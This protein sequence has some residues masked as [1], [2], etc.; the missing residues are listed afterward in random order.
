M[1]R[2]KNETNKKIKLPCMQSVSVGRAY[3]LLRADVREHL[4]TAHDELGF[5]YCRFH[6]I[7]HDDMDIAYKKENGQIGYHWHHID[8]VFDYLLSIGMK[9][10]I[11]LNPMPSVIASGTQT[12]FWYEMNVTPP[13]E[14][15]MWYDLIHSFTNH[16]TDRYGMNEVEKWFFEVWNE[17]NLDCFWSGTQEEYFTMY[18]TSAEAVKSVNSKYKIGGPASAVAE[19][20]VDLIDY[21]SKENVPL[22]FVSTHLYPM[23]EYCRYNDRE[24]SPYELGEYYIETVKKT[25]RM[26]EQSSMPNLDIYWTEWN[27]LSTDST[28]NITF[29]GNTALDRLYGASCTVRNMLAVRDY[30]KAVS[31]WVVSDIF[32]EAKMS[33]TPFSGTYGLMNI[34]GV[35]KATYNAFLMLKKMCGY[36]IEIES[37]IVYP[38]GCGMAAAKE[39]GVYRILIWNNQL[40][41]IKEQ[42]I[43][44]DFIKIDGINLS[45]CIAEQAKIQKGRGSAYESWL[46][47]GKPANPT[48]FEEEFLK[49]CSKPEYTVLNMGDSIKFS[50]K[51]DEVCY[52]ELR[53]KP[54]DRYLA[55]KDL[56]LDEQLTTY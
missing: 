47:M 37:D 34:K 3:D 27:T 53:K 12:M 42:P 14:W 11:E 50:L 7:F 29:Q 38:T 45:E 56:K 18:K 17:P 32:E 20:V 49:A 10:F 39:N 26:V 51:P 48:A 19:W 54:N 13:K 23:D 25:K 5:T 31:Y 24:G 44:E 46:E 35:R 52:I 41:E 43:W 55:Q 8:K 9:P 16:I 40:P 2:L 28:A 30:C 33:H 6:G 15:D 1:I 36:E 22:D 4:K 21:C